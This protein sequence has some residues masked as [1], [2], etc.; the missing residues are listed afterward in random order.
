MPILDARH[1]LGHPVEDDAAWSES[2]YFN[3]YD[4]GSDSGLF[5][6][7]GIRPNE[8]TMDVGLSLWLPEGDLAEYRAVQEQRTMVDTVLE[9]GDV[10]YEMTEAMRSWRLTADTDV[11]VRNCTRGS[12]ADRRSRVALDLRFD[13]ITPAIGTDGQSA[14]R[15]GSA[16]SAAA[17]GTTGKGHFEQS[18]TWTGWLEVDGTRHT[19]VGALGNRDRSWGPR[20]WGGPTMWRWFSINIDERLHF[21]GIRLGTGRGDLH[22]GWVFDDGR[23]ASIAEWRIRTDLADDGLTQRTVHLTVLDKGG[24]QY[25]LLGD[26]QRVADIGRASGTLINEG[27][28]RWTFCDGDGSRRTGYGIAEYLH[29]L[30]DGGRPVVDI[31]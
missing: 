16:E 10:R 19:W 27:L 6:R 13:S 7:V 31:D 26:V 30:D 23:A 14:A 4:Q 8:G 29:Q 5:T 12:V 11:P 2:Y 25:D 15:P 28:T 21:G 18:G 3:G 9:V 1:D 17:A 22:R 20:N 24:R